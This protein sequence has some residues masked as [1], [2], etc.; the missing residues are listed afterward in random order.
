MYKRSCRDTKTCKSCKYVFANFFEPV[1]ILG[2]LTLNLDAFILSLG[3]LKLF[4]VLIFP[5][6]KCYSANICV[7]CMS[8]NVIMLVWENEIEYERE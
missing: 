3:F 2:S 7:F 6:K 4:L 5:G 1:L 8:V